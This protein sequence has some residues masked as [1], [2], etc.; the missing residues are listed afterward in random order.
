[1]CDYR[2]G[3]GLDT[4]VIDHFNTQ[5][6]ITLNYIAIADFHTLPNHTKSFP[7][8]SVFT[9]SC[10]VTTSNNGYSSASVFKSSLNDGSLP[11]AYS[12]ESELLYDWRFTANQFVLVSSPLRLTTR[13]LFFSVEHL[14]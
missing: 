6:V 1:M 13:D 14:R 3:F 5:L 10:L 11:T 9:S 7:A 12:S 2:R 4:E 8:R